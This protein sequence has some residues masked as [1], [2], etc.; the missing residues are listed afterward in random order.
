M[1]GALVQAT[2]KPSS[3]TELHT[4]IDPNIYW[5]RRVMAYVVMAYAV[6]ACAA[7]ACIVMAYVLMAYVVMVYELS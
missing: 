2:V 6:M 5:L 7:M 1:N 3:T 4:T